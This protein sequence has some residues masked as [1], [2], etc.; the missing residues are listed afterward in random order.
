MCHRAEAIRRRRGQAGFSA[1]RGA[2]DPSRDER[3]SILPFG[4]IPGAALPKV[5][6][7]AAAQRELLR[8]TFDY[9]FQRTPA[10]LHSI[11]SE[12]RIIQV[13]DAWLAKFGYSREEVIG[14]FSSDF[15]APES[16]ADA[17]ERILPEFFRS[18]HCENVVYQMV[19]KDGRILDVLLSAVLDPGDE[20]KNCSSLAV[21]SDV[22]E[23]RAALR[24]LRESESHYRLLAEYSTDIVFQLDRTMT[25]RYVS[26]ASMEIL[27]YAP[28]ELINERSASI[29]H[30]ED[31]ERC[32]PL[33]KSLLAGTSERLT[34]I[35]RVRHR[36]GRWIWVELQ[37]RAPTD[38]PGGL[39]EYIF[40]SMR[41]ISLRKS[42]E[43]QLA[44]ASRR[45]ET[46]AAEDFLT[47]L[48]N[49]RIFDEALSREF[50]RASRERTPLALLMI[51]VDRF[52]EFNDRHGHPE[53]D[54]CLRLVARTLEGA[55]KRPGDLSA[56]YG[57]EEFAVLLP[58]TDEF[59]AYVVAERVRAAVRELGIENGVGEI[60]T[61]SA[62]VAA[63]PLDHSGEGPHI[64]LRDADRA[65]YRAKDG[66]R[67][68][69]VRSSVIAT[70]S[71]TEAL[72][73][74]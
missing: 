71:A 20:Q 44:Q 68:L 72:S 56:R 1:R 32:A 16:R 8:E 36:D 61:I 12:G 24:R 30:P 19:C 69:V 52:K 9:W 64:L 5:L 26:P 59:G 6:L 47:G 63:T 34:F 58:N 67:N 7:E 55:I 53:G 66:G 46:L 31:A 48:A 35:C 17:V 28:E 54:A 49:R 39:P 10:M 70:A 60:I 41:D 37:C 25:R 21:I 40:G 23:S 18:G 43:D 51:D 57:G 27:G 42:Y 14:Q 33:F 65:L 15:L 62:G 3:Q 4:P 13:S 73:A 22:T 74:A 29:T 38:H 50:R 45:L 2:P 11:D